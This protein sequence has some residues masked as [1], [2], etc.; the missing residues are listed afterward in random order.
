MQ[1]QLSSITTRNAQMLTIPN[2]SC[3]IVGDTNVPTL[4]NKTL[5]DSINN[6]MAK[7]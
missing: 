3:A 5:T 4:T 1:F 6:M 7:S 2:A